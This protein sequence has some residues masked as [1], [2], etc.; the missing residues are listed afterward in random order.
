MLSMGRLLGIPIF[1]AVVSLSVIAASTEWLTGKGA[2]SGLLTL[3]AEQ[4][5][6]LRL[7]QESDAVLDRLYVKDKIVAQ[8]MAGEITLSQAGAWFLTLNDT[9][10][11]VRRMCQTFP[12]SSEGESACRQVIAWAEVAGRIKHSP[13]QGE[14]VRQRLEA[15]LREHL[16]RYG[17]VEL[18]E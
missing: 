18:P 3:A 1:C 14:A 15:E 9:P 17:T 7:E 5:R 2:A 16:E 6:T 13:E 10:E 11:L 12:G 4:R 8:L